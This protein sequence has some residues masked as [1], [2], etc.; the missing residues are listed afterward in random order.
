MRGGYTRP[1]IFKASDMYGE[2]A[3]LMNAHGDISTEDNL[4]QWRTDDGYHWYE[5]GD[6]AGNNLED[7]EIVDPEDFSGEITITHSNLNPHPTLP[8]LEECKWG[9]EKLIIENV[10]PEQAHLLADAYVS[11]FNTYSELFPEIH[12]T[13]DLDEDVILVDDL[14]QGW[15]RGSRLEGY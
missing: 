7:I 5:D 9:T 4:Y 15:F 2:E 6:S 11:I 14:G 10:A 3:I 1:R 8:G 13:H 12:A